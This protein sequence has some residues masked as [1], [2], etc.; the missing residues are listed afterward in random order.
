MVR[1][2]PV[3]DVDPDPDPGF[4]LRNPEV[5]QKPYEFPAPNNT[6]SI[7]R[8]CD[9]G[10][11]VVQRHVG[12]IPSPP[13]LDL[14]VASRGLGGLRCCSQDPTAYIAAQL[15]PLSKYS[16]GDATAVCMRTQFV[17]SD[18]TIHSTPLLCA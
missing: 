2:G 17:G 16:P 18:A 6:P 8:F 3:P 4:P 1:A 7:S 15:A 9:T 13:Q 14:P 5:L 10:I 11:E 12:W